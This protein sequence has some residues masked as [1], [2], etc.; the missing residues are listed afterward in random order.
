MEKPTQ[1]NTRANTEPPTTVD[2]AN[3]TSNNT[4]M[5]VA[6]IILFIGLSVF[7]AIGFAFGHH[8]I[9]L[10]ATILDF[11]IALLF[12]CKNPRGLRY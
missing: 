12:I 3:T 6:L 5:R 2:S 7:N 8:F 9:N 1:N 10:F 11:G 4:W